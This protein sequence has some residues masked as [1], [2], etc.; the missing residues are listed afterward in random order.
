MTK[1]PVD[2]MTYSNNTDSVQ[3]KPCMNRHRLIV[4]SKPARFMLP[5]NKAYL[6]KR[7]KII[8]AAK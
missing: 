8:F 7:A 4:K 3:L 5:E 1:R 6:V 2:E